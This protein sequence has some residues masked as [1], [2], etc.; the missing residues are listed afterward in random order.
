MASDARG[1][2]LIVV[3]R[4]GTWRQLWLGSV[5]QVVRMPVEGLLTVGSR[6]DA[7]KPPKS[8][9]QY[10]EHKLVGK[11]DMAPPMYFYR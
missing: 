11:A 1:F 9:Q 2:N 4:D 10:T 3:Q 5:P 7:L 8:A 6:E